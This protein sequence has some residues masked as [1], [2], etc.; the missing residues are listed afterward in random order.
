MEFLFF[1]FNQ[2]KAIQASAYLLHLG[3]GSLDHRLLIALLYLADR[4]ALLRH[5]RTITGAKMVATKEGPALPQV[6]KLIQEKKQL[7]KNDWVETEEL[8]RFELYVLEQCYK[9]FGKMTVDDIVE[10]L[11]HNAPDW[12]TTDE[13]ST[14][15]LIDILRKNG[16]DTRNLIYMYEDTE[17]LC[18]LG[19][20]PDCF[21][22]K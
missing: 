19:S 17:L 5:G 3:S 6:L 11:V 4:E 14:I 10:W 7:L 20:F 12:V 1:P 2:N 9:K 15:Y 18:E 16:I 8:S 21:L 13:D 22:P